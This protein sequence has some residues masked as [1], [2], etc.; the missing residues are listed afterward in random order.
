MVK[1]KNNLG[2]LVISLDMELMWGIIEKPTAN[3]YGQ[4]NIR[5]VPTVID[6]L[7]H[8]FK[9]Y[10]IH[11]TFGVVGF[12]LYEDKESLMN[13]LPS[14]CP[15]YKREFLSPYN[16]YINT[17]KAE[18]CNLYFAPELIKKIASTEGME[19]GSHTFC[20]YYCT[21]KGQSLEQFR[22]DVKK[23][24]S[25]AEKNGYNLC[26]IIFPRNQ[27][28][29]K[30]LEV[31]K[32]EGIKIYRG[33]PKKFFNESNN[34]IIR[35]INKACRFADN[36]IPLSGCTSYSAKNIIDGEMFNISASRFLRP[37]LK[38]IRFLE[39]LRFNRI[40][41]E[42]TKAAK[43]G[44]IYHLWWHPHN[45]GANMDDNFE[46]LE[47]LLKHFEDLHKKYGMKSKNMTD[48]AFEIIE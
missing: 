47:K 8:L 33:N 26:S 16:G 7:L 6:R 15:T 18:D 31:C 14:R 21:E 44:H 28:S 17:I 39:P 24:F 2:T 22:E 29:P 37:Y 48:C 40:K 36:Y 4:T 1:T 32:E 13:D 46:F 23:S 11:A 20:H 42:M 35:F 27:V 34:L 5:H 43:K 45:F 12:L 41:Q 3:F 30:Y 38:K 9:K 10:N 19:I 25:I